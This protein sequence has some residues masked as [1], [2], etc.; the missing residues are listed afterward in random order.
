[1]VFL[2]VCF[3]FH[4]QSKGNGGMPNENISDREGGG[5]NDKCILI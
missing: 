3:S 2:V 1:M 5:A 4:L